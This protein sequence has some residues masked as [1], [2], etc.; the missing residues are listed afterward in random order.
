MIATVSWRRGLAAATLL[1]S[2]SVSG[3]ALAAS[4]HPPLMPLRDAVVTYDV[5]PDG[6]PESQR[7]KVWFT[8]EGARMRVDSPDGA[9]ST[10]LDRTNQAV[11][12]V[13]HRQHVYSH[14]V[15]RGTVRNPFL[16]DVSMQF[17]RKGER[18]IAGVSC[19]LWDVTTAHGQATAC[20]TADGLVLAEDGVDADGAKGKLSAVTV[21]YHPIAASEFEPPAGYQ[22]VTQRSAKAGG[23]AAPATPKIATPSSPAKGE[24]PLIQTPHETAP[25]T[26]DL[27]K[28]SEADVGSP[29]ASSAP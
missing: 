3:S 1:A 20:V 29:G 11:T 7:V 2:L 18:N 15:R 13:L 6:A 12:I 21:D 24:E 5:Q 26:S 25:D 10:I 8:T 23:T 16:L 9:A 14:L 4:E 17:Q 22:D 27:P 28:E 19:T